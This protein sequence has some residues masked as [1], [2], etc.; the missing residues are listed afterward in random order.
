MEKY[1]LLIF[2]LL[3]LEV[4]GGPELPSYML[5]KYK[6]KR[7]ENYAKF[8]EEIGVGWINRQIAQSLFPTVTISQ[9]NGVISIENKTPLWTGNSEFEIG[10]DY[11]DKDPFG[12]RVPSFASF[13]GTTLKRVQSP[14]NAPQIS[15][16]RRYRQG[17]K[18]MILTL[19]ITDKPNVVAK[20][21]FTRV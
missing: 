11:I 18:K 6:L 1:L 15:E 7:S 19:R 13:D 3:V 8:L 10:K 4:Q 2:S 9:S 21:F 16:E 14:E 12:T 20:R 5:G 17:G